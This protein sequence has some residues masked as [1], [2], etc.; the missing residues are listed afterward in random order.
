MNAQYPVS[1]ADRDKWILAKRGPRRQV[2][3]SR[4]YAYL[5]EEECGANLQPVSTATVFL[6]NRECPYRCLMCDLWQHTLEHSLPVGQ[7]PRQIRFALTHIPSAR[8][9]KLYNAGSFFDPLAIPNSDDREIAGI[10]N[11][12]ERVIVESHPSFLKGMNAER[13]LRFRD[14]ITG[15]LEIAVGLETADPIALEKMNK[16]MTLDDFRAAA[17]FIKENH[18][19]LRVFIVLKPPFQESDKAL[20]WACRSIDFAEECGASVCTIIPARKGNG[21]TD[22]LNEDPPDIRDLEKAVSYG[23]GR[24]GLRVFADIWDIDRFFTCQCSVHRARRL[25]KINRTQLPSDAIVCSVCE[26][27]C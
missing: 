15:K 18:M 3:P 17:A 27:E 7:I 20:E 22:E 4:P 1:A 5:W 19:D 25:G 16:R 24:K 2:D 21:A 9:I 10:V 8:Q 14:L 11:T 23:L 6:T 13:V 12:Y 26:E